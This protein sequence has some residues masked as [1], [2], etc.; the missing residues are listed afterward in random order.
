MFFFY[1][2]YNPKGAEMWFGNTI[3]VKLISV[4]NAIGRK[5]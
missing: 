2:P 1:L 5:V 4:D 3:L